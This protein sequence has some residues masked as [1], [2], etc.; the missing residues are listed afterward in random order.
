QQAPARELVARPLADDGPGQ[1]TDV[2]LVEHEHGAEPG[3]RER[4]ARAA[5][6]IR[7]QALEVHALLEV[8]LRVAGRLERTIPAVSRIDVLG[9][10]GSGERGRRLAGTGILRAGRLSRARPGEHDAVL[11]LQDLV[12]RDRPQPRP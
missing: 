11:V 4:L 3:F 10:D 9:A 8:H 2:V 5:E 7:V 12:S 6:A 1:I